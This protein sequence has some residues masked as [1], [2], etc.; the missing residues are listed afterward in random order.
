MSLWFALL[1]LGLAPVMVGATEVIVGNAPMELSGVAGG[2]QQAAMQVG[3]SLGTAVLGAVMASQV[4]G[5]LPG[6]WADAGLPPLTPE[7]LD[8]AVRGRRR[9]ASPPVAKDTPAEV[10]AKITKVAHDTFLSGMSL[11]FTVAGV[12]AAFAA[13]VALLTKRGDNAEAV[14]G[15]AHI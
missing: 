12:V 2:L 7:Q 14:G 11:A 9:S 15:G 10:A 6:N 1:G 4:D 13:A 5:D 3:G 8:Q